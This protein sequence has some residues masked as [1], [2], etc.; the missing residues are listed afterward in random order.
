MVTASLRRYGQLLHSEELEALRAFELL[1]TVNSWDFW[2]AGTRWVRWEFVS[3][4][5]ASDVK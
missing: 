3:K 5:K 4:M 1:V 2:V